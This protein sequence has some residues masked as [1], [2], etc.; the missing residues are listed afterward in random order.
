MRKKF[1]LMI[2]LLV[3]II[4][5]LTFIL[6]L[7]YLDP[8][9]NRTIWLLSITVTFILMSTSFFTLILYFLKK[10]HYRWEIFILHV[11]SSLRQAFLLGLFIGMFVLF[12][13]I[14]IFTPVTIS[15]VS[16]ILVLIELLFQ[17]LDN[18]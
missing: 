17:N 13:S 15:L 5:S 12:Y 9:L 3:F 6:I 14:S 1:L 4:S 8:F 11:F 16:V 2:I 18:N 7:N 10:V